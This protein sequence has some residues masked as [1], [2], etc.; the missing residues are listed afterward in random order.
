VEVLDSER[1]ARRYFTLFAAGRIGELLELVHP[2]VELVLKTV[3]PGERIRGRQGLERFLAEIPEGVFESAAEVYRP[4]DETRI[5]VEG[6]VRW[7]DEDRVLRDDPM[8]WALEFRDGLLVR[9]SPAQTVL[10]AESILA[11]PLGGEPVAD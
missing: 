11:V 3:R 5:V 1:L 7:T 6:R 10:E 4:L 2:D 9:S 8:I